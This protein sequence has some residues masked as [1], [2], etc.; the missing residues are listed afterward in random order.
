MQEIDLHQ[1]L[2]QV[3]D[4][5]H[6]RQGAAAVIKIAYRSPSSVLRGAG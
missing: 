2:P 3:F 6:E 4:G 5:L 1:L